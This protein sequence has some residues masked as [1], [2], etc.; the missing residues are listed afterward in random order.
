MNKRKFA[1]LRKCEL[2]SNDNCGGSILLDRKDIIDTI[3]EHP[4]KSSILFTE[5]SPRNDFPTKQ[6]ETPSQP[7]ILPI[8]NKKHQYSGEIVFKPSESG[9][10]NNLLGLVSA[11][12][13]A[14]L[15]NKRLYCIAQLLL[16]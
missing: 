14:A 8:V 3:T 13:I 7:T 5:T 11:F 9:L 1:V 10:S 6:P 16:C 4:L 12:V 2:Q 15:T